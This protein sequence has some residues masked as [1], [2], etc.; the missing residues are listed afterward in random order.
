MPSHAAKAGK[1]LKDKGVD[2]RA[3][4]KVQFIYVK[5]TPRVLAMGFSTNNRQLSH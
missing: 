4:S 2:V 5:G 1:Q 3:G